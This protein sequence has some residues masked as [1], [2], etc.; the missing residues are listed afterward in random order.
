MG[1][2]FL[3][4]RRDAWGLVGRS[5]PMGAVG[6]R[7]GPPLNARAD[8]RLGF[9]VGFLGGAV[10]LA[11]ALVLIVSLQGARTDALDAARAA[12]ANFAR[13]LSV[14][15]ANALDAAEAALASTADA[16]LLALTAGTLVG[17]ETERL[18]GHGLDRL[19]KDRLAYTPVLRQIVLTN[20]AGLVI[21]DSAGAL[22][23][24]SLPLEKYLVGEEGTH[25]ALTIGEAEDRRLFGGPPDGGPPDGGPPDGGQRL[26]PIA[27][28][29]ETTDGRLVGAVLGALNPLYFLSVAASLELGPDGCAALYRHDGVVLA[30]SPAPLAPEATAALRRREEAGTRLAVMPDGVERIVSYRATPQWPMVVEIGVAKTAALAGWRRNLYDIAAP[31]IGVSLAVFGLTFALMR[32]VRRRAHDQ[33]LMALGDQAL[34]CAPGGVGIADLNHGGRPF[35]YVNPALAQIADASAEQLLADRGEPA[36]YA[37]GVGDGRALLRGTVCAFD[38][39]AEA[40]GPRRLPFLRDGRTVWVEVAMSQVTFDNG[41]VYG[42]VTLRDVTEQAEAEQELLRSLEEVAQLHDEQARFSEILAHHMQEPVRRVVSHCQLLRRILPPL[43]D[44]AEHV[45]RVV[46][47]AGR[48]LRTLLRDVELY[49]SASAP[50]QSR[51]G[52]SADAALNRALHR[53]QER[54]R[55]TGAQVLR[56]AL[57][58]VAMNA[59][60]LTEAFFALVDNALLYKSPDRPL[61]ISIDATLEDGGWTICVEDNGIGI[62]PIYFDK[63][64][65]IFE[66]LHAD[67]GHEGVGVGLPL[68][69][70]LVER[71]GGRLWLESTHG[72]GS[73]FF[74][75]LPPCPPPSVATATNLI[76]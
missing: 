15:V 54:I 31:A 12:T 5:A 10:V 1:V 38:P 30:G 47:K 74:M 22:V 66:R 64:F 69:R 11:A 23:G 32:A 14:G 58:V 56:G 39:G 16:G 27:R 67:D 4:E 72:A 24:A 43:D 36:F 51:G 63:I 52:A 42:V 3:P 71:A 34:R 17:E 6:G 21:Y 57:P 73:R 53:V 13:A 44:D 8:H 20:A 40:A 29:I 26:I 62:E 59:Q 75:A 2:T 25:R 49:L 46:E 41:G 35:I 60:A 7:I 55:E 65:H 18:N 48:R 68:A 70:K 37:K 33:A 45:M 19:V 50:M 9:G 61:I 28:R 76:Q